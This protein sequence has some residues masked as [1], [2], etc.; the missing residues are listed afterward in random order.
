LKNELLTQKNWQQRHWKWLIPLIGLILLSI[1]IFFSSGMNRITADLVKA[2]ADSELYDNALEKVKA[3]QRV[4]D[5]LGEIKPIDKLAILEGEV[6]FS[7]DNNAVQSTIRVK[8][9]KLTAMMDITA[10]R[11]NNKWIYKKLNIR[12]KKPIEKK[13]T[14]EIIKPTE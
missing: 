1:A 2:Y 14:I 7:D 9:E 10:E 4:T 12:I 8:G 13:Q 5:I 3:N 11:I 6:Q